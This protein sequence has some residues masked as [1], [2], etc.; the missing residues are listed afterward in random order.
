MGPSS[1][2]SSASSSV[3]GFPRSH[4]WTGLTSA[5]LTWGGWEKLQTIK[6]LKI[7]R[8]IH[9]RT[10]TR[11]TEMRV[12]TTDASQPESPQFLKMFPSQSSVST[13]MLE[14]RPCS[15]CIFEW[16]VLLL[17][18][19]L[20]QQRPSKSSQQWPC[21]SNR[22]SI[23][24][25]F[26]MVACLVISSSARRLLRAADVRFACFT[27]QHSRWPNSPRALAAATH[28]KKMETATLFDFDQ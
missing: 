26:W 21:A 28:G 9:M 19:K 4:S 13:L 8:A 20:R 3:G 10:I 6:V 17:D 16:M 12:F 27:T 25:R 14:M 1:T 2:S 5:W 18:D 24:T 7:D 11:A 15:S 23:A 22:K